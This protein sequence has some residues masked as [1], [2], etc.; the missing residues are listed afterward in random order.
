MG[1]SDGTFRCCYRRY[2]S[3]GSDYVQCIRS[4][5]KKALKIAL[6]ITSMESPPLP[7]QAAN[8]LKKT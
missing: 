6:R 5:S 3:S 7:L 2:C 1:S 4:Q 8:L